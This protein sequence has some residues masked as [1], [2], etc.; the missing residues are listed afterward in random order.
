MSA[1]HRRSMVAALLALGLAVPTASVALGAESPEPAGTSNAATKRERIEQLKA[2][3]KKRE[4]SSADSNGPKATTTDPRLRRLSSAPIEPTSTVRLAVKASGGAKAARAA[5]GNVAAAAT[6]QGGRQQKVLSQIGTVSVEVPEQ[7]ANLVA[8]RLRQRTDVESVRVVSRR[9][10]TY[11]PNDEHYPDTAGYLAA[12]AAP[13]AWDVRRADPG[14][15]IAVVDTGVD[16]DHPDLDG[17]VTASHNAWDGG[18]DVSDEQGHGTFVAGVAAATGDNGIGIAGASMGASVLA[19]KV[20]DPSGNLWT[21]VEA[22]GIIWAADNGADVINLSLGG[23]TPDDVESDAIDYAVSK[24]V[25]VVAAAGNDGTT[26]KSYPAAYPGVIAVGAT[27]G[28]GNRASFSQYGSWVTLAAPGVGITS[29]APAAGSEPSDADY[30]TGSGT[31]FSAPLV[32][33]E[34]ALVKSQRPDLAAADIATAITRSAHGYA[35]LGLGAGQVD[36]RRALDA[37]PPTTVPALTSPA[38]G[39]SVA[40]VVALTAAS[41]AP[42]V[43]FLVD[44]EQLGSLVAPVEGAARASWST[45]GLANG[46]HSISVADCST[47]DLCNAPGEATSVTLSNAAPK[48]T[49]PKSGATVSG[50]TTFNATAPGGAVAFYVDGVRKGIDTTSPYSLTYAVSALKDG[51]HTLKVVSC[52]TSGACSGP[53]ASVSFKNL[54]LHPKLTSVTPSVFSPNGDKRRDTTKATWYLPDTETVKL[55]IRNSAGKVVRGPGNYSS[56]AK[57][58]HTYTWNGY[59][60]GGK[61]APSGTYTVEIVTSRKSGGVT[62]RGSATKSVVVDLAAPTMS[63]ITGNK[64]TIYPYKDGYKDSFAPAFTLNEKA[65]VT[66]TV[67]NSKG[68]VVR[69][70]SGSKAK[71][72]ASLSWNGRT[73]SGAQVAGGTYYWT[74]TAQ[75]TAGNRR[76]TARYSVVVSSKKLV[77]KTATYTKN[78]SAYS[79]AGGSDPSCAWVDRGSSYFSP[80]GA[81]MANLCYYSDEIAAAGYRFTVPSATSFSSLRLDTYGSSL[82]PAVLTAGY[83]KWATDGVSFTKAISTG[84]SNGWRSFGTASANG[85]VSSGRTVEVALVLPNAYLVNDYDIGK[86]RL[87][88][89]YKVLAY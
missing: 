5:L 16:T 8:E 15:H 65:T 34:V 14:V 47:D 20:A 3:Q 46:S 4:R 67:K 71:G 50:S 43:R 83:T 49:A 21:D 28:A 17:R 27:D 39:A 38:A 31:S 59:L 79:F 69:T 44:G 9:T 62:L 63:S 76:T 13:D 88:V 18:T 55:Q 82:D 57:G 32:A 42:K 30:A 29:T 52:S 41:T 78:G 74:L 84:T 56:Q 22:E 86:V 12:V 72:R 10:P 60:N 2:Q 36:F 73:A 25:V 66:L 23:A 81:W 19:V 61:R 40:G 45:W 26:A 7:V 11:V 35:G 75:D 68:K 48:I 1:V 89:T 33:A 58:W 24:G 6:A 87:T 64:A 37:V 85:L 54:S 53:S 77:T 51:T 70:I 80:Y